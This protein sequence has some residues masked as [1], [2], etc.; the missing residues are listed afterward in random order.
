MQAL[1]SSK[2]VSL[3]FE[4]QYDMTRY[5]LPFSMAQS[6]PWTRMLLTSLRFIL[7]FP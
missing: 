5:D 2:N 3:T 1:D 6:I 4:Q 7:I